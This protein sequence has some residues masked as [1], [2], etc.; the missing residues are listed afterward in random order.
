VFPEFESVSD[1]VV[2]EEIPEPVVP[3]EIPTPPEYP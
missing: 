3:E 2:P 1:P